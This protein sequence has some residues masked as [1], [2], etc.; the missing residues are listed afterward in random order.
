MITHQ[1]EAQLLA[2]CRKGHRQAQ[3]QLYDRFAG[4]MYVVCLRYCKN[5]DEA[6][7]ILQEAFI[8]IFN[9]ISSFRGESKL[10][11]WIKRVVV[12][13]ALNQQRNKHHLLPV[14]DINAEHHVTNETYILSDYHWKDLLKMIQGLP[15]GC[16]AIFN[17]YAIEG[18]N[19][20]EIAKML[21]ITEGTSKSQFARARQLL[22]EKIRKEEDINYGTTG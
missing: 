16:R 21:Q 9:K 11:Y 6:K 17:L 8:K 12:N 18:F 19:H 13:T 22:Q 5:E 3:R 14:V 2:G 20:R 10:Y 4:E 1:E 7:D 15:Q